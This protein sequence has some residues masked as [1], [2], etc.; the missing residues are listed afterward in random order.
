LNSSG[1][2]HSCHHRT[3]FPAPLNSYLPFNYFCFLS[4]WYMSSRNF[5]SV[6]ER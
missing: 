1:L 5:L 2:L 3:H 4:C 6:H